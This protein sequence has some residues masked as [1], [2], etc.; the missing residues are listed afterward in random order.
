MIMNTHNGAGVF[1]LNVDLPKQATLI[2]LVHSSGSA[3]LAGS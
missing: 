1:V 2:L 3:S